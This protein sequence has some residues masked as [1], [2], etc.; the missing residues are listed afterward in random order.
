VPLAPA[1][2]GPARLRLTLTP[3][4]ADP[5]G[6]VRVRLASPDGGSITIGIGG[7]PR[8]ATVV[9]DDDT[10]G[11][12]PGSY[13]RPSAAPLSGSDPDDPVTLD[14]VVDDRTLEAFVDGDAAVITSSTVGTLDGAGLS[15]EA[16]GGAVRVTDA[17]WASFEEDAP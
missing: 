9:R 1:P 14:V 10:H 8:Q 12:M 13:R 17:S 7:R 5:P 16:V 15:V 3:D 4:P 11:I 2:D 6:E